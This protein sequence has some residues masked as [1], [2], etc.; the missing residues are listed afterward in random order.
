MVVQILPG[1]HLEKL[2]FSL[3]EKTLPNQDLNSGPF[4]KKFNISP[5][6]EELL[7][8]ANTIA[9]LHLRVKPHVRKAHGGFSSFH[10]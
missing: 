1:I 6:T 10:K 9:Y 3:K 5:I 8:T 7:N 2:F 4:V